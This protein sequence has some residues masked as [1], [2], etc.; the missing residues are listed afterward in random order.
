[1]NQHLALPT[2]EPFFTDF[3]FENM[4]I[5]LERL[6]F[7]IVV[8]DRNERVRY[9]NALGERMY[10]CRHSDIVSKP[11]SNLL[12]LPDPKII[13][14]GITRAFT[15]GKV[16]ILEWEEEQYYEGRVFHRQ[17][18]VVPLLDGEEIISYAVVAIFDTT[19]RVRTERR[20]NTS[21]EHYRMVFETSPDAVIIMKENQQ[22]I[23]VNQACEALTGYKREELSGRYFWEISRQFQSPGVSSKDA[24]D[25]IFTLSS[26]KNFVRTEW[27]LLSKNGTG[28]NI[29]L[30]LSP[31]EPQPSART[32]ANRLLQ[33][34]L[35]KTAK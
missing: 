8:V 22:I 34:S 15:V 26:K 17:G 3:G 18:T 13:S 2:K 14:A 27:H 4:K 23:G 35:R 9:I 1:M 5:L 28:I 7:V 32:T 10:Q 24:A 19:E 21:L 20:L 12:F 29:E 33:A 11:I 16:V 31:L 30:S 6:P 25:K